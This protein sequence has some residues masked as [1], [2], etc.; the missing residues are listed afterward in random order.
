VI[1]Y[2]TVMARCSLFVL[3]VPLNPKQANK[4]TIRRAKLQ[5][6]CHHQQAKTQVFY[7]LDAVA[8][9][10]STVSETVNVKQAPGETY[11]VSQICFTC[12]L[13]HTWP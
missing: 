9:S 11:L 8:V 4:Q 2:P 3:K 10:Q 6:N 7:R 5:S 12:R 13:A 1:Y